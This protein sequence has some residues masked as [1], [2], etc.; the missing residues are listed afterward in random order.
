MANARTAEAARRRSKR[1]AARHRM[2]DETSGKPK[3][4]HKEQRE[5]HGRAR[6]R[7]TDAGRTM[8][9]QRLHMETSFAESRR[10]TEYRD[11]DARER[12]RS[13]WQL[14]RPRGKRRSRDGRKQTTSESKVFVRFDVL[15]SR[16][17]LCC[18]G[19][20]NPSAPLL[21]KERNIA[22][23]PSASFLSLFSSLSPFIRDHRTDLRPRA[24]ERVRSG[25]PSLR[26]PT[27][28]GT[29][30]ALACKAP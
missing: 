16:E 27:P 28:P 26:L 7:P 19:L 10:E 14:R 3:A 23:S 25:F 13:R 15:T 6:G 29:Q 4:K 8:W 30:A 20:S 11:G 21:A 17:R 18:S 12:N 22:S 24:R 9:P 5:G 1:R 2:T